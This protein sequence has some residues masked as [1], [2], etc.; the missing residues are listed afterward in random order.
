L[1]GKARCISEF[2]TNLDYR[3]SS[4]TAEE[5]WGGGGGRKGFRKGRR[6]KGGG[7]REEK[8]EKTKEKNTIRKYRQKV[9]GLDLHL[10]LFS[11]LVLRV[12]YLLLVLLLVQYLLTK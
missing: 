5:K 8:E 1:G 11:L 3:G 12:A 9:T 10:R 4:W 2:E 6:G 7:G